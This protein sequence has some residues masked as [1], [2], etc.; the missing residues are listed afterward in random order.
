MLF[1]C[2]LGAIEFAVGWT[3]EGAAAIARALGVMTRAEGVTQVARDANL[4]R[5]SLYKTLSE[6]GNPSFATT[7]E[8]SLALGVRFFLRNRS[9]ACTL[10]LP[11]SRTEVARVIFASR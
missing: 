8:A 9:K 1:A 10:T 4:S 11:R 5:K 2:G 3:N 6:D 7:L